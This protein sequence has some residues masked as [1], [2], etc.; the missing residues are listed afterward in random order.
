MTDRHLAHNRPDITIVFPNNKKAFL[1]DIAIPGDHSRLS[2]KVLEKQTR[3]TDLKIEIEKLWKV[4][5][6]IVTIVVGALGS[7]PA[8]LT[9]CLN[10][11]GLQATL[12]KIIQKTVLLASV[13]LII[14]YL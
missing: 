4:K 12:V 13:H 6:V 9:K 10:T 8:N 2:S 3:Y 5:R 1:V 14:R 7:I 11:I